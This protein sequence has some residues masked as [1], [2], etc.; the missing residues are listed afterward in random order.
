MNMIVCIKQV[1]DPEA[2]PASFKVDGARNEVLQPPNVSLVVDPYSAFALEAAL[3]IKDTQGGKITAITLGANLLR[4]VVKK[5]LSL[6]ADELILLEDEAFDGGDSWST[7]YALAKAI[8]KIG[9]YNLI[10]CGRE[11]AEWNAGQVGSAVAEML[12]VP[13]VTLAQK[14][15]VNDG[16]AVV[17]RRTDDGY[18]VVEVS[19]PALITVSHEIGQVRYETIKGMMAAKK[20]EPLVWKPADLGV[21]PARIGAKGRHARMLRLFQPVREGRCEYVEGATPE[22]QGVNL[23]LKLREEKIIM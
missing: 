15:D 20:K 17:R 22:E 9:E 4:S 2:P 12:A 11:D 8:E 13:S 19:L 10:F 21:D 18:E 6:G 16:S 5:S 7:A 1:L 3:K 14:I 23:A